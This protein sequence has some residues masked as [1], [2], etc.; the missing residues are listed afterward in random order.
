M[1]NDWI[2][3]RVWLSKDPRVIT[4]AD[5]LSV[6]REFMDWLTDPARSTCDSCAYEYVTRNV[7]VALCVTGLLITWGTA[8][9]QGDRYEDDLILHHAYKETL[10]TITDIPCFGSAMAH[11]GW[12]VDTEEGFITFPKFF[13]DNESPDDK[14]KRQNAERQARYR[15]KTSRESNVTDNVISNVTVTHREEKRREENIKPLCVYSEDFETFWKAYPKKTGKAEAFKIWKKSKPDITSV[16]QTLAW[17]T[18][19]DDWTKNSGQFVP[20]AS[21]YLNQKRYLDEP[22][23]TGS[24]MD[25][26]MRKVGAIPT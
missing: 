25:D 8:R 18:T 1:A 7:I 10:D 20:H 9:E 6:E 19:T 15:E 26:F 5:Y 14:H 17:Q 3:M 11:V 16:L 2:K 24:S 21:T 12:L 13:K 22:V 4:M 23:T